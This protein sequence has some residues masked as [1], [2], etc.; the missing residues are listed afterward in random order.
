[1]D[2][3]AK[4]GFD[5]ALFGM[6]SLRAGGATAAVNCGVQDRLLKR[7]GRWKSES[8]KDGW[9]CYRFP[10]ETLRGLKKPGYIAR[11]V[12]CTSIELVC[13]FCLFLVF[14]RHKQAHFIF[15]WS[16]GHSKYP[17]VAL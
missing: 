3:I 9:V 13:V 12:L 14:F 16:S 2:K 17:P 7:H 6:H 15:D 10:T 4:L 11:P 8:A 1:M 5:P